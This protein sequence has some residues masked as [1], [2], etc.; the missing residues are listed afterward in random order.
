MEGRIDARAESI[1]PSSAQAADELT[2][3]FPIVRSRTRV[4]SD[5]VNADVFRP[6]E[7][8]EEMRTRLGIPADRDVIGYLGILTEYQGI[9]CLIEA[10]GEVVAAH[11]RAHLLLLGW[12][13]VERYRALADSVGVGG[14]VTLLAA[15]DVAVAPKMVTT[16]SNLKVRDY[17]ACGLP[18]VVFDLPVNREILGDLGIF[19]SDRSSKSLA[20]ALTR[21]LADRDSWSRLG[22]RS[23]EVAVRDYSWETSARQIIAVYDR[24]MGESEHG[25][26]PHRDTGIGGGRSQGP[27]LAASHVRQVA[28]EEAEVQGAPATSRRCPGAA[29]PVDH[30]R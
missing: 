2:R 24:L 9:D 13:N 6:M 27:P 7:C 19:A 11:P 23:R 26:E 10:M 25:N 5:G 3:E 14:R 8:R 21:A 18:T 20:E 22:R 15:A 29:L 12:P 16:E 17:M 1:L 28:Q 4:V 30:V